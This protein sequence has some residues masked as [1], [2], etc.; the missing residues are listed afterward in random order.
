M[1]T[2]LAISCKAGLERFEI[3]PMQETP[4]AREKQLSDGQKANGRL[5]GGLSVSSV[6]ARLI[7][8]TLNPNL[9][10]EL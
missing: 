7:I 2:A 3:E 5:T 10:E 8:E 1:S 4:E 9:Q 6:F